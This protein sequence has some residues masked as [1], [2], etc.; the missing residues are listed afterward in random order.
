MAIKFEVVTKYK[1]KGI[2]LP[3]RSTEFSAGYDIEA[4]ED[5]VVPSLYKLYKKDFNYDYEVIENTHK[6]PSMYDINKIKNVVKKLNIRTM[7]PTGIKV[8]M[9]PNMFLQIHP[10]SGT[11]ANC[12]LQLA[13]QTAIIDADYYN[14]P[15]NEGEVFIALINLSPMDIT[16]RKGDKIAQGIFTQYFVT[17]DDQAKG[18]RTGGFGSTGV[19]E[20][21]EEKIIFK[22]ED[23]DKII[24]SVNSDIAN[25]ENK[26][27]T[28]EVSFLPQE[29]FSKILEEYNKK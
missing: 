25:I 2:N 18:A 4:A 14:N 27:N 6:Y 21:K 22:Q 15:N 7:V 11:G 12:L 1:D 16:I 20:S 10:R 9:E 23:F 19:N 8:Q 17:D 5:T 26:I 13:N 29:D 24:E 28:E 3:K